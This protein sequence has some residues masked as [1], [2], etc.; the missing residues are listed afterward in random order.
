MH[1]DILATENRRE[2][3]VCACAQMIYR[4]IKGMQSMHNWASA[5]E[6]DCALRQK[7]IQCHTLKRIINI[8]YAEKYRP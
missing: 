4:I 3:I 5:S 8:L 6:S 7:P 1:I 2:L